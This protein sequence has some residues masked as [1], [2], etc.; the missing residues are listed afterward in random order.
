MASWSPRLCASH[1]LTPLCQLLQFIIPTHW[2]YITHSSSEITL[3]IHWAH[4][5][6]DSSILPTHWAH[7]AQGSSLSPTYWTH[8]THCSSIYPTQLSPY[9][10]WFQCI[11]HTLSPLCPLLQDMPPTLSPCPPTWSPY[12][13][14]LQII[15]HPTLSPSGPW[16]QCIPHIEFIFTVSPVYPS[17]CHLPYVACCTADTPLKGQGCYKDPNKNEFGSK[18]SLGSVTV[19]TCL[20]ACSDDGKAYAALKV[21]AS[22]AIYPQLSVNAQ[23]EG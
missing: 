16:L 20:Q 3:P 15:P 17:Q 10:A 12:C 9:C 11:T 6:C 8:I 1:T 4:I 14:Y 22:T 23:N 18:M 19:P 7:I 13:Q 21:S 2:A 5:A